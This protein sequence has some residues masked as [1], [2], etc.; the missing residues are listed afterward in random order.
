MRAEIPEDKVMAAEMAFRIS[1]PHGDENS[2]AVALGKGKK[3]RRAGL[4][5]F[6]IFDDEQMQII[7][8]SKENMENILH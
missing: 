3:F 6:Y 2:F 1:E 4:R 5:P 7:V 8:T